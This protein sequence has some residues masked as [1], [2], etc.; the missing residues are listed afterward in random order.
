MIKFSIYFNR[1]VFV[2]LIKICVSTETLPRFTSVVCCFVNVLI[3]SM[4]RGFPS[5]LENYDPDMV[6]GF[7]NAQQAGKHFQQMPF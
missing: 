6:E 2:M 3:R 4:V 7:F 1:R 5:G